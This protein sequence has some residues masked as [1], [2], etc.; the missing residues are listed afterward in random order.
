MKHKSCTFFIL[1]DS[2]AIHWHEPD[3]KKTDSVSSGV[4]RRRSCKRKKASSA[5]PSLWA[6]ESVTYGGDVKE[7]AYMHTDAIDVGIRNLGDANE[8]IS[9]RIDI[10][11]LER[12]LPCFGAG[13]VTFY[14]AGQTTIG[15]LRI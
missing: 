9:Q 6:H 5:F 7:Q 15:S 4:F 13:L 10:V 11:F 12:A 1:V 2:T 8:T 3:G 14:H